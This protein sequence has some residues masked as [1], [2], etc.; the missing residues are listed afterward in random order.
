MFPHARYISFDDP[1]QALSAEG[2]PYDFIRGL[3]RHVI[4]DEIQ[5]VPSL[6]RHLKM[7]I[8][9]NRENGRFLLTGS[10]SFHLHE[11]G[12]ESLAGRVAIVE[13]PPLGASEARAGAPTEP[14]ES[15]MLRGGFPELWKGGVEASEWYP[16]YISTYLQ[17][18]LRS[19]SQVADLSAYQRFLRALA[20]RSAS[21]VN[22]ADLA[23]DVGIA[24]NTAK[25]W[26]SILV[27]SGLA[28]LVEGWSPNPM[29]RIVKSP[30]VYLNDSGLLCALLGIRSVEAL[31]NSPLIGAIW[32]TWCFCQLRI[33][34]LNRG[35]MHGAMF[36]WRTKEGK[37]VDF[38][39]EEHQ[40]I[41]AFE[42]KSKELPT[43][44][45]TRSLQALR[46]ALPE[47]DIRLS[48]L[49]RCPFYVPSMP[50]TGVSLDNG[51]NLERILSA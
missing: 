5:Y 27:S 40:R 35:R 29:S 3:G 13:L 11:L 8:D 9:E 1:L 48:L 51:F 39:I 31:R 18:D 38:I 6:F 20:L 45:D 28:S 10:Q 21:L 16:A 12:S 15:H 37:E 17:R 47:K 4:L 25:H 32:E 30:K 50:G 44:A 14:L 41:Y 46:A 42:C 26:L 23:R 19:L 7:A 24:P 22:Y 43:S 49:C 2:E 34:L 36:Y 33:W